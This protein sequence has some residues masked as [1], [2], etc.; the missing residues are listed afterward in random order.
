MASERDLAEHLN[1]R[2][3]ELKT[4]RNSWEPSWR[5]IAKYQ[6]PQRGDFFRTAGSSDRGTKKDGAIYDQVARF[7]LNTLRAGLMGGLTPRTQ[8]WF[9]LTVPDENVANLASVKTWLDHVA[10]RMLM[11]FGQSNLYQTL[12]LLYGEVGGFGTACCLMQPDFEDVCRFYPQT[13]GTYWLA[14]DYRGV[15]DTFIRRFAMP[16]R[17]VIR[18]YGEDKVSENV[19]RRAAWLPEGARSRGAGGDGNIMLVH[20]IEPNDEFEPGS[21]GTKGKKYRSVTWEEGRADKLLRVSGYDRWPVLAP[22]WEVNMDDPYGTGCGHAADSDVKSLQM[23]GK[24][25]H[26]AVDKHVNPP[27]AFPVELK[28]QASGTTP[29]FVNY[30]SGNLAEKVG[31]PL[32]QTNPSVIAPLRDLIM[33]ERQIIERCYFADLFLMISQMEG[34]QPRNQLEILARKEE[35]LGQL[36]PVLESLHGELLKPLVDWAFEEMFRH[37]LFD[38][39][40]RE[41]RGWPIEIELISMLAQ[42]QNAARVQSIERSVGFVG[43]LVGAFPQAGDKLDVYDAIDKHADAIGTPAGVIRPTEEAEA[44]AAQRAQQAAAAQAMQTGSA[45]AQGAKTLS[46]AQVGDRNGLEAVMGVQPAMSEAA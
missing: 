29:G 33:D 4:I 42:A 10:E 32:Y 6:I 36:G 16:A 27:M 30:F 31:R 22:R 2:F 39:P 28:N 46:E 41:L 38:E 12:H 5:D 40:P 18:E 20:C 15:T 24:R 14:N 8:P 23:L 21:F 43:S 7:A 44:F 19:K 11:V 35:K 9:R 3:G 1:I 26:N 45:L 37:R 17:N 25:R 34:V 13:I